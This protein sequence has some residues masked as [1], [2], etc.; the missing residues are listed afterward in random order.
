MHDITVLGPVASSSP[1]GSSGIALRSPGKDADRALVDQAKSGDQSAYSELVGRYQ[2]R[3]FT[4]S[5][6]IL[7]NDQDAEEVTQDAFMRALRGIA[8]FRGDSTFSTWLY[9]IAINLA[10]NRLKYNSVRKQHRMISFDAPL[11]GDDG[12]T[13]GEALPAEGDSPYG[14]VVTEEFRDRIRGGMARISSMH[15]EILVLRVVDN[16]SYEEIAKVLAISVGTVKSRIS[17]ARAE[18]RARLFFRYPNRRP[19]LRHQPTLIGFLKK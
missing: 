11:N 2:K 9:R 16:F 18:L 19:E 13:V 1:A 8:G 5:R 3:I 15:R 12:A 14:F 7:A 10:R 4:V 6:H 17:R